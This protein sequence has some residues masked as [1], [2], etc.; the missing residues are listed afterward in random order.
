MCGNLTTNRCL[1]CRTPRRAGLWTAVDRCRSLEFFSIFVPFP[2]I[3]KTAFPA[4]RKMGP[5]FVKSFPAGRKMLKNS[6]D[7]MAGLVLAYN[8]AMKMRKIPMFA[9]ISMKQKELIEI[10]ESHETVSNSRKGSY[11]KSY[12]AASD[13]LPLCA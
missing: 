2:A 4:G 6:L 3:P 7:K 5:G 11:G 10:P 8:S 9:I 1:G 13:G 12:P